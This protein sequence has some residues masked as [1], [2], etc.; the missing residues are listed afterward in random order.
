MGERILAALVLLVCAAALVRLCLGERRRQRL[1]FALRDGW[2]RLRTQVQRLRRYRRTHRQA[3]RE[4]EETI[5]R[6][7]GKANGHARETRSGEDN[8]IRPDS[9]KRPRKPH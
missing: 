2:Q 8:V 9:F 5:R 3:A 1:D 4:A 7:R 6:A